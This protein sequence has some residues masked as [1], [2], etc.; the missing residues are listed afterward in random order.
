MM[1]RIAVRLLGLFVAVAV[2]T[3]IAEATGH[4]RR[5]GC[6]PECWCRKPGLSLFRWVIPKAHH[7]SMDPAEKEPMERASQSPR[8]KREG[9]RE[10]SPDLEQVPDV[11]VPTE[12][13]YLDLDG[14][15]IPDAVRTTQV[16]GFDVTGDGII[17]VVE[18]VDEVASG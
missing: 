15:G 10:L 14:D 2:V 1:K 4:Y 18:T 8:S 9:V 11:V 6:L 3:R 12:T 17:D 16:S 7:R 13:E 5:C